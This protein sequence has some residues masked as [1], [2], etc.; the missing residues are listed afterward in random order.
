M[1]QSIA[2]KAAELVKEGQSIGLDSG[3]TSYE[4]AKV[5][6]KNLITLQLLLIL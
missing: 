1:K 2:L 5:L 6:K 3:T 4:L